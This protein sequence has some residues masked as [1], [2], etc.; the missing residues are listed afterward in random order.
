MVN[1]EIAFPHERS[2]D[3]SSNGLGLGRGYNINIPWP[4]NK[5]GALD[6]DEAF[7]TIVLPALQ[8]FDPEL[9]LVAS[10]FDAVAGDLLAGTQLPASSYHDLT[11]QLLSLGKP[12]AVILEGGYSPHLLAQASLNVVHALLGLPQ[13]P[14]HSSTDVQKN[15]SVPQD[16]GQTRTE[17]ARVLDA[18]RRRLNSLPPWSSMSGNG[19]GKD[20]YF[21]DNSSPDVAATNDC[22]AALL[23]E[24][25]RKQAD[26]P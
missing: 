1:G 16:T 17:A 14:A 5:V 24:L 23:R 20:G 18:V 15:F 8:G 3:H 22:V 13:P 10:G 2:M 11:R 26:E 6:Y 25:I 21:W 19:G 12:L 7:R 4:H 9:I